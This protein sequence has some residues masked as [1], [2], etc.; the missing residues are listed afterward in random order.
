VPRDIDFRLL[1][2]LEVFAGTAPLPIAADAPRALPAT[3]L[4]D[5]KRGVARHPIAGALRAP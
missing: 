4:L 2:P 3:L 1:G 5:A